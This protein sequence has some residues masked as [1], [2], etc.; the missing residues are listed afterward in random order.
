M[1]ACARNM[2]SDSAEIKPAQCCIKLVFH[3]TYTMMHGSTKLKKYHQGQ[4]TRFSANSLRGDVNPG[5]KMG[6]EQYCSQTRNIIASATKQ[7]KF[8]SSVLNLLRKAVYTLELS[9]RNMKPWT[10]TRKVP[11]T[12]LLKNDH[13]SHDS[14]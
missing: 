7:Y 3:L 5:R 11:N 2:Q 6:P 10:Q 4:Q 9:T 14:A 1:G 13:T 8:L 12:W